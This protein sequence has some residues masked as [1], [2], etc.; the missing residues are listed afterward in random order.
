[1]PKV[2]LSLMGQYCPVHKALSSPQFSRSITR[3]EYAE[4]L[5]MAQ[6]LGF[7]T[8]YIQ[9]LQSDLHNLLDFTV[10]ENPFP[11]DRSH[12]VKEG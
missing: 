10:S 1:M 8:L 11:L 12:N 3:E 5:Q 6:D 4:A 2:P 7:D 9:E